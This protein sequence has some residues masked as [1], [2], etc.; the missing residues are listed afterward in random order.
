MIKYLSV[1]VTNPPANK[2]IIVK[3]S[4]KEAVISADS[5]AKCSAIKK[6]NGKTGFTPEIIAMTLLEDGYDLWAEV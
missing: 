2:E 4:S 6:F 5:A 3:S 1:S